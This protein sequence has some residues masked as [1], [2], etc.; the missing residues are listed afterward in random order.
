IPEL[1]GLGSYRD[2]AR[3]GYSVDET[4]R[5][6]QRFQWLERAVMRTATAHLAATPE[7][8]VKCALAL[9]Q[10]YTARHVDALRR[11]IGEMRHPVPSLDTAPDPTLDRFTNELLR[12]T[13]TVELLTGVYDVAIRAL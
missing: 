7:W 13:G 6:L 12:S 10:W 3:V 4:V 11:R 5:R 1:A 2:A 9:A 8:E